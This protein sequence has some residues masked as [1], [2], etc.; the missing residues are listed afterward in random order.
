[1]ALIFQRLDSIRQTT[2]VRVG[3]SALSEGTEEFLQAL[4]QPVVQRLTY[5]PD[6]QFDLGDAFYQGFVGGTLGGV[7]QGLDAFLSGFYSKEIENGEI[8]VPENNSLEKE[9]TP[10]YFD[11]KDLSFPLDDG[12]KADYTEFEEF[13]SV[14][15]ELAPS[16][17]DEFLEI[18]HDPQKW[19]DLQQQYKILDMYKIDSGY[20]SKTEI[21]QLDDVVF[22]EKRNN[23]IS[24]YKKS[25]N[26]A[27]AFLNGNNST[28]YYAHS[29]LQRF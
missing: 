17:F 14:L 23:F 8:N 6:A 11:E 28:M 5:D 10:Y 9:E 21:F 20:L 3:L 19:D 27:G 1:M 18:K 2:P 22:H 7:A 16:S 24:D 13:S 29:S 25:G 12:L 15:E 26:I 4:A